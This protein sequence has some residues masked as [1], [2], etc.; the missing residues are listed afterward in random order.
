MAY[1]WG[2]E[3]FIEQMKIIDKMVQE[4]TDPV[5][6]FDL[7][8][9]LDCANKSYH[10][11]FYDFPQIKY[12]DMDIMT[13][14]VDTSLESHRYYSIISRF[15][16]D[17]QDLE[18]RFYHIAT[19][20]DEID[21][22]E[23]KS[24]FEC[25]S[26]VSHSKTLSLVKSF[27]HNFDKELYQHFYNTF[28]QRSRT[29]RFLDIK[30]NEDGK[31][32]SGSTVFIGGVN[33]S[34]LTLYKT[35]EIRAYESLVHEYGHVIQ[36]SVNPRTF[37]PLREDYFAEV[38]SIFPEL[39]AMYENAPGFDELLMLNA[40]YDT[41]ISYWDY[42]YDLDLHLPIAN[43]WLE[44]NYKL[45]MDF[46]RNIKKSFNLSKDDYKRIM[47]ITLDLQGVY[48]LSYITSLE[49]LNIY[50]K[51]K[52]TALELFKGLLNVPFNENVINYVETNIGLNVRVKDEVNS[53]LDE[54]EQCLIKRRS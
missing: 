20:M 1:N 49:L 18:D 29:I 32:I 2:K 46:F 15:V 22:D 4:E 47:G 16:N 31:G 7:Q 12:S 51:D 38:A 3:D 26:Y 13:S 9:A 10:G 24:V 34:Y 17:F 5:K 30:E 28:K 48:V 19:L 54:Y 42:A 43:Q 25:T 36:N 11:L 14:M 50:K 40:R 8:R 33:K 39:V 53:L 37:Y 23:K 35:D 6:R 21:K 44:N 52:K 45:N 41:L 27:Y